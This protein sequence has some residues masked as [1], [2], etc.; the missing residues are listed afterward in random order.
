MKH[1]LDLVPISAKQH[2]KQNWMTRL[3]I[4]LAVFLVTVIFSMADMEMRS[5]MVQ[6]I[7][8]DGKWHAGF[9][10]D[11][12]QTALLAAR[13][14]V[15]RTARYGVLNY[16]LE[17]GYQIE[18]IETGICGFDRE[19]LE[20]FPAAEIV[21]GVFP[22]NKDE[23]VINESANSRLG[24]GIGDTITLVTPQGDTMQ[25]R[26][27]GIA[28]E[29]ALTARYDACVIFLNA[30][31]FRQ[32]YTG[33]TGEAK[34]MVTFAAFRSFCN[35]QKSIQ[36]ISAQFN[37]EPDEV[38]QNAKV[39][40]LMFQSRDPYMMGFYLVAAVLAALVMIAGILMITSSMNSN[41]ARR[42][43]FFGM[44][45]CLGA[46]GKQVIRFVRKEALSWCKSA[47]PAGVLSGM[48]VTWI[49]CG[50]LRFLSPGFFEGMP[51]FG[52][53]FLGIAAGVVMGFATVLLAARTPAR[54]AAGVSP[55]TAVSGNAGTVQ[56]AKKA[57]N[58]RV[59]RVDTALGVH[60]A[61]GSKKNFFLVSGS[62]AFS[63]ILFLSFG[64][65]IDFMH[66]AITPLRPSAPD[67]YVGSGDTSN[68]LPA[69]LVEQISESAYVKRA[70]GRSS[71][72]F[73][74]LAGGE[75]ISGEEMIL[76]VISYD[77]QQFKWAGDDLL[78]GNFRDALDGKGMLLAFREDGMLP[79]GSSIAV[80]CGENS[81]EVPVAGVL[82][83]VPFSYGTDK[84]TGSREG[85]A[86]CSE[87]LFRELFGDAG[88]AVIDI[89]FQSGVT[90]AQVQ[91]LRRMIE[92][93]CR[94]EDCEG[95]IV[96]SDRRIE[97]RESKGA[98]YSLGVFL[99]GFLTVI[100][101]IA[102]FN[103]LNCI[104]MSVSARM[105]EYGAM[106]AVGMTVRQIVR[107]V[108]GETITYTFFG[109]LFGCLAGLPL[110]RLLFQ[111]LVTE[112]WGDA[113]E[114]PGKEFLVILIVIGCS[115]VLAVRGPAKR[116]RE[117]TVVDTIGAD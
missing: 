52:I 96:F 107:M 76:T 12:E 16:H 74:L 88:Y 8:S 56:A 110:N 4:V 3:C 86:I 73:E 32:I 30:E 17:E 26:I 42:T 49:L 60:H 98:S 11:D 66:H 83:S 116:I 97:N 55:L 109:V 112:R 31:G 70:F 25:Y 28:K 29:T 2:R 48:A 68:S 106:R 53:S 117:M 90:D 37:L 21:E 63:I 77:E 78:E 92:E 82:G 111:T 85:I 114:L 22:E 58:T 24:T 19:L 75:G 61:I 65:T 93:R 5:Q 69:E 23:A 105:R 108:W 43:E 34:E 100:A 59:F 14:E 102:F 38:R 115:A 50:M 87:S 89:Q 62:F 13:P 1:Y 20:L 47:I 81:R 71:M 9:L 101:L 15:E 51:A 64:A 79:V 45:R 39:L 44:M 104:A 40:M 57:A 7:Q 91:E 54:R 33:D 80:P 35:I 94:E 10:M 6:A 67:F 46:T 103:I 27:T 72:T 84:S 113:W 41:I 36:E 95:G 18:G 99:Y